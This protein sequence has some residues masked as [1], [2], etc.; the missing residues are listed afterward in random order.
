MQENGSVNHTSLGISNPDS[1]PDVNFSRILTTADESLLRIVGIGLDIIDEV[2][3]DGDFQL[4]TTVE[5][6]GVV[7]E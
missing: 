5:R 7:F 6:T 3:I 4:M 2:L 1:S